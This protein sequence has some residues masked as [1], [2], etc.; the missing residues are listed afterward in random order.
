MR[1]EIGPDAFIAWIQVA[2]SEAANMES[3][4]DND[5]DEVRG[6]C[7]QLSNPSHLY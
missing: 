6:N 4:A 5:K 1:C 3:L 7:E 2:A